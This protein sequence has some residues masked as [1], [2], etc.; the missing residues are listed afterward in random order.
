MSVEYSANLH[1]RETI[2]ALVA[3]VADCVRGFLGP[4]EGDGLI[5]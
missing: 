5:G 4:G 3:A 1:D 2:E